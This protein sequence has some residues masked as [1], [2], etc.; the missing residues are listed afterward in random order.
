MN[1]PITV[2]KDKKDQIKSG[3]GLQEEDN[4]SQRECFVY[5]KPMEDFKQTYASLHVCICVHAGP[6]ACV[7]RV[8]SKGPVQRWVTFTGDHTER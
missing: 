2:T 4:E 3:V 6:F 8:I 7:G 5:N 1:K